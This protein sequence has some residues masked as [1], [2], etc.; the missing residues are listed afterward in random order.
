M[1]VRHRNGD[2]LQHLRQLPADPGGIE[3]D[4]AERGRALPN[5][6]ATAVAP[7]EWPRE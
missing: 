4:S 1:R 5:A 2:P 7:N 6:V 3:Q